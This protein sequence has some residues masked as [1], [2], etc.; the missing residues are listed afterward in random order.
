MI[1]YCFSGLATKDAQFMQRNHWSTPAKPASAKRCWWMSSLSTR[2]TFS[3]D[4]RFVYF[5]LAVTIGALP[6]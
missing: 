3:K 1:P 5:Q 4:W 2:M 6:G